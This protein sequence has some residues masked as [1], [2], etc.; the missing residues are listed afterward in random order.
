MAEKGVDRPAT[1]YFAARGVDDLF[2]REDM[3]R[4]EEK[5]PRFRFVPVLSHVRPEEGWQGE[6][7]GIAPA[8]A[9]LLSPRA[10]A[11]A[12]LCGSPGMIDASIAALRAW[13]IEEG[14]IFFDKFS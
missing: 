6:R 12:Y 7:G 8:L 3:R 14:S 5:L 10:S 9:R 13:G 11:E 2:Y 1:F 4:M